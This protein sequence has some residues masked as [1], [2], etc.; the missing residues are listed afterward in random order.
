[1]ADE[2]VAEAASTVDEFVALAM[3]TT[4]R[5]R[6]RGIVHGERGCGHDDGDRSLK[7]DTDS[8]AMTT[9]RSMGCDGRRD[10]VLDARCRL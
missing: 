4:K 1:M 3:S 7:H 8:P 6:C 9:T 10:A 2:A 5:G